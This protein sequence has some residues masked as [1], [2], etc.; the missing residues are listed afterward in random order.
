MVIPAHLDRVVQGVSAVDLSD[1]NLS[2]LD[3]AGINLASAKLTN[4]DF[5]GAKLGYTNLTTAF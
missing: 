2:K 5:M 1:S 3:L 4:A